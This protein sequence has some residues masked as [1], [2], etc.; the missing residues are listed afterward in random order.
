LELRGLSL[1]TIIHQLEKFKYNEMP[2]TF[3]TRLKLGGFGIY[4]SPYKKPILPQQ[5][6]LDKDDLFGFKTIVITFLKTIAVNS[7][8][9]ETP[10]STL[11]T[12]N[13]E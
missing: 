7:V 2:Y 9:E 10:S 12:R 8:N 13:F 1:W 5:I 6:L 3:S 4:L 11:N